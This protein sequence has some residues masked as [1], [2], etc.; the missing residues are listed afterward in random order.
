[1]RVH[2][3]AVLLLQTGCT[4]VISGTPP[5]TRGDDPQTPAANAGASSSGGALVETPTRTPLRRLTRAQY[6]RAV[7]DLLGVNDAFAESFGPDELVGGFASNLTTL[8]SVSLLENYALAAERAAAAAVA[9]GLGRFSP[10]TPATM[11]EADCATLFIAAFGKRAFRRPLTSEEL[12]R[13]QAV[14]DVG[15][16][17]EGDFAA[18]VTLVVTALLQS[19]HFLYLPELGGVLDSAQQVLPLTPYETA[20]RLSFFLLGSIPDEV[21]MS[22]AD[23]GLLS[24]AADMA[25]QAQRLLATPRAGETLVHFHRQW[26]QV[27]DVLSTE[28]D[29]TLFPAFGA[30]LK[31]AM[32]DEIAAFVTSVLREGD[33]TLGTLL[34]A[35]FSVISG[36]LYELHGLAPPAD[37]SLPARVELPAGQRAGLFTLPGV[38]ATYAHPDQSSPVARGFLVSDRLLCLTPEPPPPGVDAIVA[39]PDP[40]VTTRQRLEQHR[41]DPACAGCHGLMDP[42]GLT[43]EHFDAIGRY[44]THDGSQSVDASAELP[45]IGAVDDAVEMLKLLAES[46][47]V[48]R[49]VARQWFRFA[50][51]RLENATDQAT[52]A[53]AL[54]GFEASGYRVPDLLVA[55]AASENFRRRS[56][57]EP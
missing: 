49:C 24:T 29:A 17:A 19:P 20:A 42:Y 10:C 36:P 13:Y 11:A 18:G 37:A 34:G 9:A 30:E 16:G 31:Q 4:G 26:L 28:K 21:L 22:A 52:I 15:R 6:E 48:R 53:L 3:L 2:L 50:N 27:N 35:S 5:S 14:Y 12:A 56:P 23:Q 1:M 43:F 8:V 33:G 39:P 57:I 38:L 54:A 46:D 41:A 51:G 40:N 45:G 55:L 32:N 25:E 44:R 47:D 7:Q